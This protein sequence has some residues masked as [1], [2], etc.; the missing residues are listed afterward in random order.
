MET[1]L[2]YSTTTPLLLSVLK[3]LMGSSEYDTFR[4]VGGTALSLYRGHRLSVD[5]D[6]FTDA[7][8]G[9]INFDDLESHLRNNWQYVDTSNIFPVG[10]GKSYFVG[11]NKDNCIKLDLFYTDDFIE[12]IQLIDGIRLASI[13]EILAMKI[14][15]IG[16]GGRKKDFW[17]VHELMEHFSLS[18]ML[19]L[20]KKRYPFTHDKTLLISKLNDFIQADFDFEPV[21]LRKKHWE[22]IK[23]D[24]IEF[25]NSA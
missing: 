12:D 19:G 25:V 16:R 3:R 6:L 14:D 10:M 2:Y 20:H 15:V 22:I 17:D 7:T 18:E 11:F 24:L 8:Y 21:C 4:L 9:S 1:K 23:L 5:I 13:D